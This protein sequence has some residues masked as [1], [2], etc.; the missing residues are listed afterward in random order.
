MLHVS[1]PERVAIASLT[2]RAGAGDAAALGAYSVSCVP[3][4]R[5]AYL[6]LAVR[7]EVARLSELPDWRSTRCELS[8]SSR[9]VLDG[10][11][12]PL[13]ALPAVGGVRSSGESRSAAGSIRAAR[14]RGRPDG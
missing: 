2:P 14:A 13:R 4:A 10:L 12:P 8:G 5:A 1:N 3:A 6:L 7:R 11:S 9:S